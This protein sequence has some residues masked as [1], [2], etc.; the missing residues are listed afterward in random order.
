MADKTPQQYYNEN[1]NQWRGTGQCVAG[2]QHFSNWLGYPTIRT[3][4]NCAWNYGVSSTKS[5]EI[6]QYY[7]RID[8]ISQLQPGDW[9]ISRGPSQY[10]HV[11]MYYYN[12][13]SF[14]QNQV[15]NGGG[16]AYTLRPFSLWSSSFIC[17]YRPK[18]WSNQAF[19]SGGSTGASV[20]FRKYNLSESQ[21][22]G[23]AALCEEEQGSAKGAA[24][25]ASLLANRFELYGASKGH[26]TI[27][28]TASSSWFASKSRARLYA[29]NPS[30]SVLEAVRDVLIN[31][32][33]KLPNYIDEHDYVGDIGRISTGNYLNAGDYIQDRTE[34]YQNS[35]ISGGGGHW[36]FYCWGDESRIKNGK[37]G[38]VT[39]PFGYSKGAKAKAQSL[40]LSG[41]V[42]DGGIASSAGG[43]A[44]LYTT[45]NDRN[46]ASLRESAYANNDGTATLNNTN[47]PLSVI[48]YTTALAQAYSSSYNGVLSN[49]D[50]NLSLTG[51]SNANMSNKVN[52]AKIWHPFAKR[53]FD[54]LLSKG[55]IPAVIC[56][57]LGNIYQECKYDSSLV[58][59]NGEGVG[60]CQWSFTR[61]SR[62]IQMVPDWKTCGI[63]KQL[64]YMLYE[65]VNP[66]PKN[67]GVGRFKHCVNLWNGT[68][69]VPNNVGVYGLSSYVKAGPLENSESGV[70]TATIVWL[71]NH[72]G[73][74]ADSALATTVRIPEARKIWNSLQFLN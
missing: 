6:Q 52:T 62:F 28:D 42:G 14:G 17:G 27:W 66:D 57:I 19:A 40:G 60:L 16:Y 61:K 41:Q 7:V 48:N 73:P 24:S 54:Y 49:G 37:W 22:R 45:V 21:L 20:G 18:A 69:T 33:R 10:G 35:N 1:I 44:P 59:S 47:M 9:Y 67:D 30:A 43:Y 36:T 64:D 29:Q 55:G 12:G 38:G 31:G 71:A 32:N 56:G 72:E 23:I 26:K 58:E 51:L 11:A 25:E 2:F 70:V 3:G 68:V 65:I 15:G 5:A 46:D 4:N 8:N 34:V 74:S 63:E 13:Q 50:S 39:D 53:I